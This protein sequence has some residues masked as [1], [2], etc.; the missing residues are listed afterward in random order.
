MSLPY[1]S[2]GLP[3]IGL[4]T[5]RR[6]RGIQVWLAAIVAIVLF[7]VL[8]LAIRATPA[9][10]EQAGTPNDVESITDALFGPQVIPFE[11]LGVL[12]TAVMI[13]ALVTARPLTVHGSEETSL[14]HPN[15]SL[16]AP[17]GDLPAQEI[18]GSPLMA[19]AIE[20]VHG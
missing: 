14:V 18:P 12:L 8:A 16:P 6:R 10:I 3:S 13:G 20:E 1:P 7:A 4:R 5:L 17:A 19:A 11:V 15:L 9:W 2:M